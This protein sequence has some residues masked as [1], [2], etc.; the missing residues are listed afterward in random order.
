MQCINCGK[1]NEGRSKYCDNTCKTQFH[2]I[3]SNETVSPPTVSKDETG[4]INTSGRTISVGELVVGQPVRSR[5][6]GCECAI[7]G[8]EDYVGVCE[9]V[10]GAWRVKPEHAG[11]KVAG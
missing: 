7:P 4:Y 10:D 5:V 11:R 9:K 2:R 1:D 3:V 8:D 6:G